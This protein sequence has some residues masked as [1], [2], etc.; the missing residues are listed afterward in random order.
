[1][2]LIALRAC[3]SGRRQAPGRSE[4]SKTPPA[5]HRPVLLRRLL[6]MAPSMVAAVILVAYHLVLLWQRLADMSLLQPAVA[7]RWIV[8]V[9]LLIGLRR[10]HAAGL[11]LVWGRR[12]LAFW[13]LVLLLHVSFLGPLSE[14][15]NLGA[16]WGT[17]AGLALVL[18]AAAPLLLLSILVF[19]C[20]L[21]VKGGVPGASP[22]LRSLTR[23][24]GSL[25]H[26]SRRGWLPSLASRPPPAFS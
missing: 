17:S 14:K 12:A 21:A 18:P 4:G 11:P 23:L 19:T 22:P 26:P 2:S 1:M 24:S 16:D 15:A 10:M 20:W 13:L 7:L 9:A 8:T 25:K 3:L 5:L 6:P